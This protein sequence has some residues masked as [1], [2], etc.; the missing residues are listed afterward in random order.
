M[1]KKYQS[2]KNSSDCLY[3]RLSKIENRKRINKKWNKKAL[4]DSLFTWTAAFLV[5]VFIMIIYFMFVLLLFGEEKI[6]RDIDIVFEESKIE[7]YLN[8]K[9]LNFL[10]SSIFI[11]GKEEKIIYI[12]KNSLNPYFEIKNDKEESFV[13]K[14]GLMAFME[15]GVALK[16]RM[17]SDGFDDSDWDKLIQT[18]FEFQESESI[19]E[20]IKELDKFCYID[21]EDRY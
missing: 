15:E 6:T 19:K 20:I 4:E 18:N 5:I 13:E 21:R 10:S 7:L 12:I 11:N 14:F 8:S 2:S 16:N 9:F 17:R 1:I 3:A